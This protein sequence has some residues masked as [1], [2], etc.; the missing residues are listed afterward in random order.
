MSA[1]SV[2]TSDRPRYAEKRPSGPRED[3]LPSLLDGNGTN[4]VTLEG[5]PQGQPAEWP[6]RTS[7]LWASPR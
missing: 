4:L 3:P 2:A 6:K 7:Q 5:D 1:T